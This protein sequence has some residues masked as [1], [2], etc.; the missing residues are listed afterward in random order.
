MS[1]ADNKA[2]FR[3][4]Y[5]RAWI[6]GDASVADDLL[7]ADF[8]NHALPATTH[9]SHRELYRQAIAD[10]TSAFPDYTLT[11]EDLIAEG[12][13]VV[14]RWRS[15]CMDA[16]TSTRITNEGITIVRSVD[17]RI[18]EFWKHDDALGVLRQLGKVPHS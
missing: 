6:K 9:G 8:V 10:N 15:A 17:G 14:A 5:V 7:A 1:T 12:A 11:I 16:S 4:F 18:A 3:Q 2:L 13:T